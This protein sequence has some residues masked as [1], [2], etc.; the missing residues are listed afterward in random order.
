MADKLRQSVVAN[1][2]EVE[3]DAIAVDGLRLNSTGP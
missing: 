1:R 2:E 3:A